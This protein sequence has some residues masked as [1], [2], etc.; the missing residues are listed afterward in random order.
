MQKLCSLIPYFTVFVPHPIDFYTAEKVVL[1]PCTAKSQLTEDM[2]PLNTRTDEPVERESGLGSA[3]EREIKRCMPPRLSCRVSPGVREKDAK[4]LASMLSGGRALLLVLSGVVALDR[5]SVAP[6]PTGGASEA[7]GGP[8]KAVDASA[9]AAAAAAVTMS[10]GLVSPSS[11]AYE[12]NPQ[13]MPI[14]SLG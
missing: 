4:V 5:F 2:L 9:A 14:R 12:G 13:N 10:R 8:S 6:P 11:A 1:L 7:M 3:R